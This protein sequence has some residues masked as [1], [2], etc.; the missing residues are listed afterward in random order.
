MKKK[1]NELKFRLME[2]DDLRAVDNILYWDQAAFMP[3][4]GT[5]ARGRQMGTISRLAH[6]KFIDPAIGRL[7]DELQSF[8]ESLP[9]D[10]DDASL[11][12]V[13]RRQYE[14]A[15]KVPASFKSALQ[16]HLAESYQVWSEARPRNDFKAVQPFLEKTLDFSRQYADFFPGYDHIADPLIDDHDQG[17]T[18]A[19]TKKIFSELRRQLTPVVKQIRDQPVIDSSFLYR[20]YSENKQWDFGLDVI[21]HF[22]YD[23]LRGRLD[24]TVHPFMIK[25]SIGD[26]RITTRIKEN[27]L[28]EYLFSTLHE[29]GHALYE[30]NILPD[31]EGTPLADGASAGIHESQSRL[32]ENI[33]GRSQNFWIYFYP[34]LQKVFPDRLGKISLEK[35]YQ[36]INKVGRSL[37][38]TDADE[39][40]YNLHVMIRFDLELA[41]LEGKLAV[42]DLPEVWNARYYADLGQAP[43]DNRDGVLQDMH[44]YSNLIGG[45]FQGYTLGNI[46]SSQFY[47]AALKKHSQIETEMQQ[48]KFK[49]LLTWLK[50]NIYRHGSKYTAPELVSKVTDRSISIYPYI[51]YLMNKYGK[52]Y[53]F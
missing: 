24:K 14:R 31:F 18:V 12:R 34:R 32:W 17:M 51:N 53:Q 27:D 15:I 9:Y 45:S 10:S 1:L 50:T 42:A 11:V 41:L 22:G 46:M 39:L 33:V 48:G 47:E 2:I 30:Q 3:P 37:I 6:E 26:V 19:S 35:F 25:F 20:D 16:N 38:R 7:L 4:G 21:R 40:T 5:K 43:P 36:G 28:S 52:I 29:S 23:F 44:W 13:T 49:T 8:E